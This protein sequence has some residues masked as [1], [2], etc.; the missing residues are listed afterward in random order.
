MRRGN[1]E[2]VEWVFT[3]ISVDSEGGSHELPAIQ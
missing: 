3:T 2:E 1:A